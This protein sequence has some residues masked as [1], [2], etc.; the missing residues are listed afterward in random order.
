MVPVKRSVTFQTV[1]RDGWP[2][3]K[4]GGRQGMSVLWLGPMC[5]FGSLP[6]TKNKNR[7]K[8]KNVVGKHMFK[9]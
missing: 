4:N 9:S 1:L 3:H 8:K 2:C 7:K 5:D 6:A